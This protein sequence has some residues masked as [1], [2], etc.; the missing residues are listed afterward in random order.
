MDLCR[1]G[2]AQFGTFGLI[3]GLNVR[4]VPSGD[5][6]GNHRGWYF[7][8]KFHSFNVVIMGSGATQG[9]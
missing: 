1:A 7:G 3:F 8:N 4:R 2:H 6:H 9:R 5:L